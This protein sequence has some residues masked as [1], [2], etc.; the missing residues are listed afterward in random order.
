VDDFVTYTILG[1]VL[2][3]V[4]AIAASGLVLTYTTSGI[5]NFAHGAQAMLSAFLYWQLTVPWG[6]PTVVALILVVGV[7]GPLMGMGLYRFLMKGL[8]D[9]DEVTKVIVTVSVLLGIV[10]LSMWIWEPSEPR[11]VELL[12]GNTN[13]V[14][15]LGTTVRLGEILVVLAAV[16]LAVGL[17]LLFTRHRLGVAM[18]G[19]V[20]D[21]DLLRLNGFNPQRL[22]LTSWAL[23]AALAAFAGVA[24]TPVAGGSLEAST[25]TLLIIDTFAAA[26]FGRLRSIP[27][28]FVGAIVLGLAATYM[29]GYAPTRFDW[30]SNLR[31]ALPVILLFIVLLLLP[32]DRLRGAVQQRSR[33]R[34]RVPSVRQALV[35][36][37]V[38]VGLVYLLGRIAS[39][40]MIGSWVNAIAFAIVAL[41]LVPLTGY[42]GE[43]NLVPLSFSAV[44]IIVAFHTGVEGIGVDSRMTWVGIVAGVAATA[45]VGGLVALPA[46]RLRGLYLAL[47]TLAFG[48]VMS[49]LVLR[50]INVRHWFGLDIALFPNARLIVPRPEV[51]P[52]DL[53]D[54]TTYLLALAVVFAALGVLVVALRNSGYGR[55][56]VAMR[57][58]PAATAM[59]GQRLVLLKLGVFMLS[60]AIAGLGGVLLAGAQGSVSGDDFVITASL[61]LVMLTVV[62]GVS[63]VSGALFGGVVVGVGLTALAGTTAGLA[64]SNAAL[65]P[66]FEVLA[67]LGGLAIALTGLGVRHNPTGAVHA[68]CS[69]YRPL[70]AARPVLYGGGAVL[71][72]LVALNLT[73]VIGD[74]SFA[75]LVVLAVLTLP[76]FAARL[77]P[78]AV[79]TAQE[80]EERQR[81]GRDV[82][83]LKGLD[84]SLTPDERL[85]LDAALGLRLGERVHA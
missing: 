83:E 40:V 12:F 3:A 61:V 78:A 69:A 2:G 48:G 4:Y 67:H 76:A 81:A 28:T 5:F 57:D 58:S 19:V 36:G 25:L 42:A 35:W 23:G 10:Q 30:V 60:A 11:K 65:A 43:I 20:D 49:T 68:I 59:L 31:G 7:I 39:P 45:V 33:E 47:A 52:L 75:L 53:E 51:G 26:M 13:S 9:V 77:M 22:A 54:N 82:P 63:Y 14:D 66:T 64:D 15:I 38:F 44:G 6:V 8:R 73:E 37:A 18:R 34:P 74:W 80:I 17:R 55:R 50:E 70:W 29:V 56:L 1:L 27:R 72:V 16:A 46:L 71:A 21:P 41:S 79:L 84:S 62:G 85:D 32:Q 24:V